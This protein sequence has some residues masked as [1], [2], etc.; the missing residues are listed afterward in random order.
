MKTLL[1]TGFFALSMLATAGT[2]SAC[3]PGEKGGCGGD[4]GQAADGPKG[5]RGAKRMEKMT[6]HLA[7]TAEQQT[8]VR[9]LQDKKRAVAKP[10]R[11]KMHAN[12]QALEALWKAETLDVPAMEKLRAEGHALHGKIADASFD[13]RVG[14]HAI[15]TPEQREKAHAFMKKGGKRGRHHRG[16]GPI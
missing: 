10:L 2:A 4:C 15:L 6:K 14:M 5:E 8:A 13:F 11:D 16:G 3:P 7:L 1:T 12:R 9:K